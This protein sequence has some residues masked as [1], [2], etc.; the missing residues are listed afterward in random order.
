[1]K[2]TSKM[3]LLPTYRTTSK[4]I[5]FLSPEPSFTQ[6]ITRHNSDGYCIL[7]STETKLDSS[8]TAEKIR[9]MISSFPGTENYFVVQKCELLAKNPQSMHTVDFAGFTSEKNSPENSLQNLVMGSHFV[10]ESMSMHVP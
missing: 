1:M 2:C 10:R 6:Y 8:I 5:P 4:W 3:R 7:L 9:V